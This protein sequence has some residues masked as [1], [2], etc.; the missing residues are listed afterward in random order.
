MSWRKETEEQVKHVSKSVGDLWR[1]ICALHEYL[2]VTFDNEPQ[3]F[4]VKKKKGKD[5][6]K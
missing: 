4:V 3:R 1:H 5:A 6:K 2:G